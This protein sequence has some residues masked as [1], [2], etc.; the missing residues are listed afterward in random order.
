MFTFSSSRDAT[1]PKRKKR[2]PS[3]RPTKV[4]VGHLTRNVN[5]DHVKEIFMT[6]GTIKDIEMLSDRMH[7]HFSRGFAY[8]EYGTPEEA[9]KAIRHMDGGNA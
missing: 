5:K 7:S 2:S 9:E 1:S 3:P 6:Y 4:H 8:I